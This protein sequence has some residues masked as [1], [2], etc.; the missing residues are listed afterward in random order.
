MRG[1][2]E[3]IGNRETNNTFAIEVRRMQGKLQELLEL[4]IA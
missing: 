2:P 3:A 4:L 1:R